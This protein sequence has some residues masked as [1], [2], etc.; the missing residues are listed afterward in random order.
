MCDFVITRG[1]KKG[2]K[3]DNPISRKS[4]TSCTKHIDKVS[5]FGIEKIKVVKDKQPVIKKVVKES[6]FDKDNYQKLVLEKLL[7]ELKFTRDNKYCNVVDYE[8][9]DRLKANG[10]GDMILGPC[11]E[12][13][14]K[15]RCQYHVSHMNSGK[16]HE[17]IE[18][19]KLSQNQNKSVLFISSRVST[20]NDLLSKLQKIKYDD[21]SSFVSY[22]SKPNFEEVNKLI[23]QTESLN[24]LG[25]SKTFDIVI[26]DECFS[27]MSQ[28]VSLSTHKSNIITNQK[29][30]SC[31]LLNAEKVILLDA[32]ISD[33]CI[34][35]Y[36][37]L[38]NKNITVYN[39]TYQ[40][41]KKIETKLITGTDTMMINDM[42]KKMNKGFNIAFITNSKNKGHKVIS[43]V[44]MFFKKIGIDFNNYV[45]YHVENKFPCRIDE[46]G[47]M[48]SVEEDFIKYQF[49]MYSPTIT[50]GV[51]FTKH[52]FHYVY[53]YYSNKS[54]NILQ[55]IQQLGRV[56]NIIE[57][58]III[59][60]N[61]SNALENCQL[62]SKN[63]ILNIEYWR[64]FYSQLKQDNR[65]YLNE[66]LSGMSTEFVK[67]QNNYM[68]MVYNKKNIYMNLFLDTQLFNI[69]SSHSGLTGLETIMNMKKYNVENIVQLIP[70]KDIQKNKIHLA[71]VDINNTLTRYEDINNQIVDRL[72]FT[73]KEYD[74]FKKM[75]HDEFVKNKYYYETYGDDENNNNHFVEFKMNVDKI[76]SIRYKLEV[77]NRYT[78]E[79]DDDKL[80]NR[81]PNE[82][83][84]DLIKDDNRHKNLKS[85]ENILFI[86]TV[87]K[88]LVET[89][90]IDKNQLMKIYTIN[91]IENE[92]AKK[93]YGRNSFEDLMLRFDDINKKLSEWGINMIIDNNLRFD[94][95]TVEQVIELYVIYNN[96]KRI[97]K[98][99]SKTIKIDNEKFTKWKTRRLTNLIK[100]IY[101]QF[102][103]TLSKP[104]D[105]R[106][107]GDR[108][109]QY[110]CIETV[111]GLFDYISK[112]NPIR[113]EKD[114]R[115]SIKQYNDR[116]NFEPVIFQNTVSLYS[117]ESEE[118]K[119]SDD[120]NESDEYYNN[121]EYESDD[122]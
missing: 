119:E 63:P 50:Q 122:F 100:E 84:F 61:E 35:F 94:N 77:F 40:F 51:D 29:I 24:K 32:D 56:R 96:Y 16:S 30:F 73:S 81:I 8:F 98:G 44:K 102:G 67:K 111:P 64:N 13:N 87:D 18:F 95:I 2:K 41:T 113:L 65:E 57:N 43:E 54:N 47:K 91:K 118:S 4:K 97:E 22:A 112:C 39:N 9:P 15:I 38:V 17:I 5:T 80:V 58:E 36:S 78:F 3:C 33:K 49:V 34:E 60:V 25:T 117:D 99:R 92:I 121:F 70:N 107:S 55:Y 83:L 26:I 23:I 72:P 19:L 20:G 82:F 11:I 10:S 62:M 120:Y 103:L 27:A 46:D 109:K 89:P 76:N 106:T 90:N 116:I 31:L 52:H 21:E 12:I 93:S 45:Y 75:K 42:C 28:M 53:G 14:S 1:V 108:H 7:D 66:F 114:I 88:V 6:T 74:F 110:T 37:K 85:I 115:E 71:E 86:N 104:I 79:S 48:Y 105:I 59:F 69:L 68:K 101:E